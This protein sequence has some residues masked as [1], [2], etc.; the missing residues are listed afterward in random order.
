MLEVKHPPE[1]FFVESPWYGTLEIVGEPGTSVE[2]WDGD[3]FGWYTT[4]TLR[5]L[6]LAAAK[7]L[8]VRW[9]DPVWDEAK[10]RAWENEQ[11]LVVW[12]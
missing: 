11:P 6:T 4:E 12:W 1:A 8:G 2:C 9:G 3:H 5:P 10:K 7:M